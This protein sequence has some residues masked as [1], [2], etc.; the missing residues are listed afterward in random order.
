MSGSGIDLE[1]CSSEGPQS[2]LERKLVE[3]YLLSKGYHKEDLKKMPE[4]E[5]K[6]LMTEACMYASGKLAEL[7]AKTHFRESIRPPS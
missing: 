3:E 7:E 6:Q 4:E 2:V 1:K 5:A